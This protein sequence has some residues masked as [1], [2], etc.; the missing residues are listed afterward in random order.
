M[1]ISVLLILGD[2]EPQDIE[3]IKPYPCKTYI[4]ML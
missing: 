1:R 2:K 3:L 4:E